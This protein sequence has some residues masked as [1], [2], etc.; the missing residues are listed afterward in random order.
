MAKAQGHNY[1]KHGDIIKNGEEIRPGVSSNYIVTTT[2]KTSVGGM[3]RAGV[4][5][6]FSGRVGLGLD[7][8]YNANMGGTNDIAGLNIRLMWGY[9][10]RPPKIAVRY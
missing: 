10:P 8:Y 1:Y 9:M 6:A 7:V 3:V 2:E 4:D 5:L